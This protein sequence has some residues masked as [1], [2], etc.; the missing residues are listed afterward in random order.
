VPTPRDARQ[1]AFERV[2]GRYEVRV[3]EPSPPAVTDE[4]YADDPAA[5]GEVPDGR[6]L[7]SPVSSGDVLWDDVARDDSELAAWAAERWLGAW[8][9]LPAAPPTLAATRVALHRLAAEVIAPT[10]QRANGRIGLRYTHGGFGTPF[11]AADAQ[12]RV[13]G[14]ELVVARGEQEWR[15]RIGTLRG[16]ADFVGHELTRLDGKLEDAPLDVDPEAG[17]FLGDW[18]GFAA[19]V[20]EQLRAEA[21]PGDSAS[22]VQLWPE[23]FDMAVELGDEDAGVRATYGFS[24][25]DAAHDEPYLY[26]APWT[27]RPHGPL[28]QATGFPGA[29]LSLSSLR[30]ESDH[31][32]FALGFMR[33]RRDA[34]TS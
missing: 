21:A 13:E 8:R 15:Q 9:P 27:A 22:L 33:S 26:V 34:L 7:V 18:Y 1:E 16:A 28:W 6:A 32:E 4:P 10:R 19:S 17:R 31:R 23:H 3:L 29:E 2:G 12:I 11:F 24:P 20:L 5:R 30:A 25:G 14:A